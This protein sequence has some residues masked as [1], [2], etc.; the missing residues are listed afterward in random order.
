MRSD[1]S[2]GVGLHTVACG[3]WVWILVQGSATLGFQMGTDQGIYPWVGTLV[4]GNLMGRRFWV[5]RGCFFLEG[6]GGKRKRQ[7]TVI[8]VGR[9]TTCTFKQP[10][11]VI[12][13]MLSSGCFTAA[14][15]QAIAK[16]VLDPRLPWAERAL[17]GLRQSVDLVHT[18]K[19]VKG[20]LLL[21][22]PRTPR[23]SGYDAYVHAVY[24]VIC[25]MSITCTCLLY[26]VICY[27]SVICCMSV[28]CLVLW[29]CYM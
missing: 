13:Y 16:G 4:M 23:S 17:L 20:L 9:W 12:Y 6:R 15:L 14:C 5:G 2:C 18:L 19:T 27:M 21:V 29:P 25:Y 26:V 3:F 8:R 22:P 7:G 28:I 11:F 1:E 24:V 10:H